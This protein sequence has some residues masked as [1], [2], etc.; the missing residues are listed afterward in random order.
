MLPRKQLDIPRFSPTA[1]WRL[2]SAL[3]SAPSEDDDLLPPESPLPPPL[4]PDKSG[5]SGIS[6]DASPHHQDSTHNS[7]VRSISDFLS[8]PFISDFE[9]DKNI[10]GIF[11]SNYPETYPFQ[12]SLHIVKLCLAV[13]F[14]SVNIKAFFK[15]Q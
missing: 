4:A 10:L 8:F 5:D 12:N 15:R 2:L 13:T 3:E 6:G 7:Q 1:A 14:F 9:K 11:L